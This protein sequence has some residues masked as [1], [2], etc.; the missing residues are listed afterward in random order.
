[1]RLQYF[2]AIGPTDV[3]VADDPL[4]IPDLEHD[5]STNIP[6]SCSSKTSLCK[7]HKSKILHTPNVDGIIS[8]ENINS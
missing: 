4:E 7:I 8:H 2:L 1:M 6:I 3:L 5:S